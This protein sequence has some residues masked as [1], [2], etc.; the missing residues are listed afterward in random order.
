M[1]PDY[2][3][4]LYESGICL[5]VG[6]TLR[7]CQ[8]LHYIAASG[9]MTEKPRITPV[10][11]VGRDSMQTH[12]EWWSRDISVGKAKR[13][14]AGRPRGRSSSSGRFKNFLFSTLSIPVLA[15]TQPHIQW[16]PGVV[17]Q[18]E[19]WQ[20]HEA[21]HSPPTSANVKNGGAIPPLPHASS[22]LGA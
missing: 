3:P 16:V 2:T 18:R 17:F 21:G 6:V 5:Y 22:W 14:W 9:R 19:K 7:R 13:L 8:R 10:T 12:A 4:C 15:P 11:I 1:Q 20:G